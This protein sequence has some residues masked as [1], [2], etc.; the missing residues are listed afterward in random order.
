MDHEITLCIAGETHRIAIPSYPRKGDYV[1]YGG[2]VYFVRS[3]VW[4][5][6]GLTLH[7]RASRV[8]R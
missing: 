5:S 2:V 4:T 7:C 1:E 3:R 8:Y 6:R